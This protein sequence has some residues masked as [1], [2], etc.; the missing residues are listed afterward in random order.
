ML[1]KIILISII[2]IQFLV[3]CGGGGDSGAETSQRKVVDLEKYDI[4]N[5]PKDGSVG[6]LAVSPNEVENSLCFAEVPSFRDLNDLYYNKANLEPAQDFRFEYVIGESE[7]GETKTEVNF[8]YQNK[9][10]YDVLAGLLF[11]VK[12]TF[13]SGQPPVFSESNKKP[14][15][16]S[17]RGYCNNIEC[18]ADS[19]FQDSWGLRFLFKEKF[20][21]VLS[22]Y[23]NPLTEDY[24]DD[25]ALQSI[26]HAVLSL[27]KGT[28]PLNKDHYSFLTR[29]TASRNV[30]IAPYLSG[31][32]PPGA[33]PG[34]AAVA[35][36]SRM[37]S[38]ETNNILS[39]VDIYLL[40]P[41]VKGRNYYSRV[42]TVFHE[43]IHVL[44]QAAEN[45]VVLSETS[46]WLKLSSWKYDK[47]AD[48]WTMG[49]PKL[50]C[51]QYGGTLPQEDFAE[52]GS[53]YRFAP[54]RLKKISK[55][56]YDFFKKRVFKNVEYHEFSKC[57]KNI[58]KLIDLSV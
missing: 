23:V 25:Q 35:A 32:T 49:K 5:L 14:I 10:V 31:Q 1:L 27:P 34:T 30:V 39:N 16:D 56:K 12:Q 38:G 18:V 42:S 21:I 19:V 58:E 51:S 20:G 50:K 37:G 53:L 26:A 44:D 45:G 3:S 46:E 4:D 24:P 40:E 52:C 6:E 8:S 41:W 9:E 54:N 7:F 15:Y 55:A 28:F 2:S 47:L 33:G 43:L 17:I 29:E 57:Q 36:S 48:S 22:G 11:N 13:A